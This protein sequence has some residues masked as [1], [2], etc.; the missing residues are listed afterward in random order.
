M[1]IFL[2][3]LLLLI[4]LGIL[5]GGAEILVR[6][7]SSI[8]RRFGISPLVVGLTIVAFGTSAPELIVSLLASFRGSADIAIGNV[9]GSNIVNILFILGITAAMVPLKV[10]KSTVWKEIPFAF[11]AI[12]LVLFFGNDGRIDGSTFNTITRTDGLALLSIFVIFMYYVFGIAKNGGDDT[13]E[14]VRMYSGATSMAFVAL[15]IAALFAGG[16][17]LVDNAILLAQAAGLSEALIGLTIV[18]IG[19]SLP[20]LVTSV[21]AARHKQAD[22]AVGNIVGSNIFNV[23]W[24][25]GLSA[26]ITPLDFNM[27]TN[28]DVIVCIGVTL[29]LFVV[30]FFGKKHIIQRRDGFIFVALYILYLGAII[31]RN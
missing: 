15:G 7:A 13:T 31:Y 25:L 6:G 23:F 20:E 24:I 9:V 1:S 18:A 3:L 14:E 17:M 12:L 10:Q 16:K 2:V 4:G 29:L 21:V 22:I 30:M 8:A 26:F 19:T 11:L 5:I 27:K 28:Q